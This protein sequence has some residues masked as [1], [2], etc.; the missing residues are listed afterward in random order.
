MRSPTI[1]ALVL[2]WACR[3]GDAPT[4]DAPTAPQQPAAAT[5][6]APAAPSWPVDRPVDDVAITAAHARAITRLL[7]TR[8]ALPA[9]LPPRTSD[10]LGRFVPLASAPGTDPLAGF[11]AALDHLHER[12]APQEKLRIA[13]FG[14]SGTAAERWTGYLRAYLQARFGDGGPGF[15][16]LVKHTPWTRHND[17][18]VASS[19]HWIRHSAGK[20]ASDGDRYGLSGVAMAARRRGE[21][22]R[23]S[24]AKDAISAVA[25]FELW[26]LRQPAGGRVRID[27]D[28]HA[29]RE[30]ATAFERT[31][32]GYERIEVDPGAHALSITT[33]DAGE[34]RI[35]GAVAETAT[36]GIVLDAMG[37][38]G[39]HAS[40]I[41]SWNAELWTEH[42][43]RRDPA[44]VIM[45]Y[46]TNEAHDAGFT[47]ESFR[48]DYDAVLARLRE[49][50]PAASCVLLSPGD[51]TAP[52]DAHAV[53]ALAQAREVVAELAARHGCAWWD[54]LEFMGGAGSMARWVAADPPLAKP[55]HVHTTTR[56]AVLVGMGVA[57]ALLWRFDAER[58]AAGSTP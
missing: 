21:T 45:A 43:R 28:G 1:A 14:A 26:Y 5:L 49:S 10:A 39:A 9:T 8:E 54:A 47:V 25:S 29:E 16:P 38:V 12:P 33:R 6:P 22:A 51:H 7:G 35:F 2:A 23:I 36:P 57:D 17:Y 3:G 40:V 13:V 46:G 56:G 11:Y 52:D 27:I 55:D 24:P 30:L 58:I 32:A 31:S 4:P 48:R 19:Q 41:L 37:I 15:V 53:A 50:V 34:V 44:L 42:L 20:H 18:V